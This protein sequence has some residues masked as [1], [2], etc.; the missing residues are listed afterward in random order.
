MSHVI[1]I[2]NDQKNNYRIDIND[3]TTISKTDT[4]VSKWESISE[5]FVSIIKEA[6]LDNKSSPQCLT[7][8]EEVARLKQILKNDPELNEGYRIIHSELDAMKRVN[9]NEMV[10]GGNLSNKLQSILFAVIFTL[11][12][13]G[14]SYATAIHVYLPLLQRCP[15]IS[16]WFTLCEQPSGVLSYMMYYVTKPFLTS[17][18]YWLSADCGQNQTRVDQFMLAFYILNIVAIKRI[19]HK[20]MPQYNDLFR[21]FNLLFVPLIGTLKYMFKDS[22][23]SCSVNTLKKLIGGRRKSRRLRMKRRKTRRMSRK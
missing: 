12:T 7:E 9:A 10:G 15:L 16:G 5:E 4:P 22:F 1:N 20:I 11:I 13:G 14:C 17:G 21:Y 2:N 6:G 23:L 19:T 8:R 18:W 3:M